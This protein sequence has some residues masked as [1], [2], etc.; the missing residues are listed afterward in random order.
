MTMGPPTAP[1]AS[2]RQLALVTPA[3]GSLASCASC[4]SFANF[5][6]ASPLLS[7]SLLAAAASAI[8]ALLEASFADNSRSFIFFSCFLRS[9][10]AFRFS[11]FSR[12]V[13]SCCF[14]LSSH[15]CFA[16]CFSF[17]RSAYHSLSR[18]FLASRSFTRQSS[19]SFSH[20][21]YSSSSRRCLSNSSALSLR[22]LLDVLLEL[23]RLRLRPRDLLDLRRPE[24]LLDDLFRGDLRLPESLLDDLFCGDLRRPDS[25]LGELLWEE[26]LEAI[27]P[28]SRPAAREGVPRIP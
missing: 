1:C 13:F 4:R 2:A 10:S 28:P 6:S 12:R 14:C 24:S 16:C 9:L 11:F 7:F 21:L 27:L 25:W 23:L 26:L 19:Y 5:I 18:L 22:Q 17:S 3:T 20:F 15:F 8:F